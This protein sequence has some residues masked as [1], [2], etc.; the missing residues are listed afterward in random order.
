M[1]TTFDWNGSVAPKHL[2]RHRMTASSERL[3]P[4]SV[5]LGGFL[6]SVYVIRGPPV[7]GGK[8]ST[9]DLLKQA[10]HCTRGDWPRYVMYNRSG[11]VATT[12][13]TRILDLIHLHWSLIA[14]DRHCILFFDQ[15]PAH[16]SSNWADSFLMK[17]IHAFPLPPN[18]THFLQPLD[19]VVFA[20]YQRCRKSLVA[21][22]RDKLSF[23]GCPNSEYVLDL[24]YKAERRALTCTIIKGAFERVGLEPRVPLKF[25]NAGR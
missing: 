1:T 4:L 2:E 19:D 8:V 10:R 7:S 21:D 25:V 13:W 17:G 11:N 20:H 18:T 5:R 12:E 14:K 15:Y 22:T 24:A 3:F 16:L 9:R 23:R 6:L